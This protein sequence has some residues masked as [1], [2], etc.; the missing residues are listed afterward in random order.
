MD[1]NEKFETIL[2]AMAQQ[3]E[4][5]TDLLEKRLKD[6]EREESKRETPEQV[7]AKQEKEFIEMMQSIN[8]KK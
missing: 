8:S 1:N 2:N 4:K 6:P 5:I 7:A 3:N